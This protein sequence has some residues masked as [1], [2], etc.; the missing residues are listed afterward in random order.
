[1]GSWYAA[2]QRALR[3]RRPNADPDLVACRMPSHDYGESLPYDTTSILKYTNTVLRRYRC[4]SLQDQEH[5][6]RRQEAQALGGP[7]G[8]TE[9]VTRQLH[10]RAERKIAK[11]S[12][13]LLQENC[14]TER[15]ERST[16]LTYARSDGPRPPP[17]RI[18]AWTGRSAYRAGRFRAQQWLEGKLHDIPGHTRCGSGHNTDPLSH[19]SRSASCKYIQRRHPETDDGTLCANFI[20]LVTIETNTKKPRIPGSI[21]CEVAHDDGVGDVQLLCRIL[22]AAISMASTVVPTSPN[23]T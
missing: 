9:Y 14:T 2:T 20:P 10:Q 11:Y 18:P 21:V 6:E 13:E 19:R 22:R 8:Q 12:L 1:M 17:H 5:S 3:P 15:E 23:S 16:R 7:V 4:W